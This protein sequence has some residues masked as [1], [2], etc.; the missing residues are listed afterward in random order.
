MPN[1]FSKLLMDDSFVRFLKGKASKEE[2]AYW[3]D[4]MQANSHNAQSIEKGK[5]LLN[6]GTL[7]VPKP[8]SNDEF[9]RLLKRIESQDEIKS[10]KKSRN[11]SRNL[12]WV[13]MAAA[14]S[15]LLLTGY[16]ARNSFLQNS[17]T[18]PVQAVSIEYK[19]F[20]TETG[21]KTTVQYSDGSSITLNANSK[22][23]LPQRMVETDTM[24]V[25]LEGEALF[26]ITR[27]EAPKSR[28]F[29]VH[30]PDGSISVLGTRFSVYTTRDQS[31]VV[32][33]EGSVKISVQ[34][35]A[36]KPGLEYIM[37]PGEKALFSQRSENIQVEQVNTE[38]YTSWAG[39]NL[40]LDNTPLSDLISRIEFTYDVEVDVEDQTLLDK[41]LTGRFN[42]SDL[43]F[44]LSGLS[45]MLEADIDQQEQTVYIKEKTDS[46][47]TE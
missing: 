11:R 25:W 27:K 26:N 3:T 31:Q 32:L 42:N 21:Q 44:L 14:I 6:K 22:M 46:G 38:V 8:N 17:A 15:L 37:T 10:I 30:T 23:R 24:Q 33:T 12:V 19:E 43:N 28:T 1:Q 45:K 16:L 36:I 39:S 2:V 4:W 20:E 18:E 40:V 41:K 29:I 5:K 34:G 13:T 9:N 7:N 47:S 35:E